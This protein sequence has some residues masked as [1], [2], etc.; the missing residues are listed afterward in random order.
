MCTLLK[1]ILEDAPHG[2]EGIKQ[3]IGKYGNQEAEEPF[4]KG[5]KENSQPE[6][7]KKS[8]GELKVLRATIQHR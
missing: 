4:H 1:K 8:R 3:G 2:N 5:N 7:E 6:G